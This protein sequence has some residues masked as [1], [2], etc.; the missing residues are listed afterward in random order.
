[1]MPVIDGVMLA[2]SSSLAAS[3]VAKVTVTMA[4]GLIA[5][6]LAR[7]NRAAVR[8][9]L[10]AAMFGTVLLLPIVSVVMPPLHVGVPVKVQSQTALLQLGTGV[11]AKPSITTA[12]A[13]S[14]VTPVTPQV[15]K[16]SLSNL[17]LAGWAVGAAFFLLPVVIG[18][19]QIR[20]LRRTGL[21]WRRGQSVAETL[22]LDAGIDRC[23]EVLLH[24]AVP[25]PMTCGVVHPAI[26]LPRDAENWNQEDLNR[27]MVHE[28]EHVRRGDSVSRCLARVADAMYW[29][30]PMVWI[31]WRRLLLEAERS[32][33]DAVLRHSEPTAYA[34]Q[35]V[36]LAKRLLATH[37]S[38]L[39]AMAN[40]GDLATRVSAV[41]DN[42]QRRGRAGLLSLALACIVAVAFVLV[43]SPLTM[44]RA[45][46]EPQLAFEVASVRPNNSAGLRD[47]QFHFLPSGRLVIRNEPLSIIVAAAYDLPFFSPRL[48]GGPEWE[49]IA[50]EKYDI[51]A[52]APVGA[53]PPGLSEKARED[54]MKLMLQSLLEERF[55]LKMRR[56]PKEQPV[57][58]IV[59]AKNGPKLQK[60]KMQEKD[61][62]DAEAPSGTPTACHSI[63]GGMGQGI[64]GDAVSIA[65]VALYVQNW[66]DRPVVDKTG[67]TDLFNI[68]TEGW[69]PTGPRPPS[70]DGQPPQGGDAGLDDPYRQT[71]ADL[72]SQL[73][74]RMEPQRAVV[75][76]FFV[77]HVEQPTAN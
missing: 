19:W 7:G 54:K 6:W 37:G 36:C 49:H 60:A 43:L 73:G 42:R 14:R 64:H 63:R 58:A 8:H 56:E 18:L 41:L 40:R 59:V 62:P 67:L 16:L 30:H 69:A 76:M 22:A 17:L 46:Q 3:I 26:F 24:E 65:D 77:E 53:V 2:V 61:C 45:A 25:G 11:D 71:L 23:V 68:Q 52:V 66:S 15:S 33:D 75:D 10:L 51:E 21:P 72:F 57:Y 4:L 70:P 1:M 74:L 38:P 28:L 27:A 9:A 34:D 29:F 44:I 20:S 5:A 50:G 39:L 31:A 48:T 13:A 35:L 55:K 12:G 47:A 32:C